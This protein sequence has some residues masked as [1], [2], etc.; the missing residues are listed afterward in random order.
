VTPVKTICILAL[1]TVFALGLV[2]QS[3]QMRAAAYRTLGLQTDI[4]ELRTQNSVCLSHLSR[5]KSPERIR[6]LVDYLGI[7]ISEPT[8]PEPAPPHPVAGGTPA[9]ESVPP[10][11]DAPAAARMPAAPALPV[12]NAIDAPP[13]DGG[14]AR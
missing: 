4:L 12:L 1:A 9:H 8:V 11:G 7:D 14:M 2:S 13:A 10:A 6:R 5:L 3:A